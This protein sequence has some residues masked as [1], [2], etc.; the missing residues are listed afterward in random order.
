MLERKNLH[1]ED[2]YYGLHNIL[3]NL[4]ELIYL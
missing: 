1:I 2:S 3:I 4:D